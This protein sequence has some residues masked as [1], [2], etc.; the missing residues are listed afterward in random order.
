MTEHS[1]LY[2]KITKIWN[3]E[4]QELCGRNLKEQPTYPENIVPVKLLVV[5]FVFPLTSLLKLS[6]L[7]VVTTFT[8]KSVAV[9]IA[10][11]HLVWCIHNLYSW[12]FEFL[13]GW[14]P[15]MASQAESW[16]VL[17][18]ADFS[19]HVKL[20]IFCCTSCTAAF[21]IISPEL[22]KNVIE[23]TAKAPAVAH[24]ECV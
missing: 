1:L 3:G 21:C 24:S 4:S 2:P 7:S 11:Q 9:S 6:L 10:W 13:T 12:I 19:A 23:L 17:E 16:P 14:S 22:T 18:A 5:P 20:F 15:L 8:L